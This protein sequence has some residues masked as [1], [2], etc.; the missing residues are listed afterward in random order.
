MDCIF[1][2]IVAGEIPSQLLYQDEQ[3][4]AFRD[5]NPIAP[6][7]LLIVPKKH[8]AS[9]SE[10]S[11]ADLPVIGNMV[12]AGNELAKREGVFEKGYRL[13]INCGQEG[14]QAVPHLHMHLL[15]GRKLSGRLG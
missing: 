1:C 8:I 11:D 3:V 12:K 10:L 14:G 7:H 15:G 6:V 5:I 4:I 9:L 2:K 13:V